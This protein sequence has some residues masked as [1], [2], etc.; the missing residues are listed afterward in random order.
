M[1]ASSVVGVLV[2]FGVL[3]ASVALEKSH[4]ESSLVTLAVVRPKPL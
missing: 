2:G 1:L 4:L 3:L